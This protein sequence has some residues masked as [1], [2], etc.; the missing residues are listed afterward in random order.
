MTLPGVTD[1]SRETAATQ[2][3]Y[4]LN[5]Q[6]TADFGRNCLLAR[7]MLENGVRFV[8]L[9]AGSAFGIAADQ[10]GRA[11]GRKA[12]PRPGGRAHR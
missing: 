7:R 3:M 10:L 9:F 8:Q 6:P 11:R 1:L 12:Q 5:E 4:G 2:A